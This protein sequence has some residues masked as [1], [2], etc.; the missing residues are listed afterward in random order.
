MTSVYLAV[1]F[2]IEQWNSHAG[3][4]T[5]Y[6]ISSVSNKDIVLTT[7]CVDSRT[8]YNF[9]KIKRCLTKFVFCHQICGECVACPL[10]FWY[11]LINSTVGRQQSS[12]HLCQSVLDTVTFWHEVCRQCFFQHTQSVLH[13]HRVG[14]VCG[15]LATVQR[16]D[17]IAECWTY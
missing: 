13:R 6:S 2:V 10:Q 16:L 7:V 17:V 15:L 5:L 9:E 1:K 12:L 4:T 3:I 14:N 8:S 11:K